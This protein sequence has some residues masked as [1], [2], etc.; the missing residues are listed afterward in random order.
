[1]HKTIAG[2]KRRKSASLC[3][4]V[5]RLLAITA[6]GDELLL[7]HVPTAIP[8]LKQVGPFR[9]CRARDG[10]LPDIHPELRGL[11]QLLYEREYGA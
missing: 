5:C 1:M 10:E 8:Y 6:E 7:L 11:L 2:R 9:G 4:H 3:R